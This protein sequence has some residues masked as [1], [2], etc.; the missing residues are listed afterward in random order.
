M[1]VISTISSLRVWLPSRWG[2]AGCQWLDDQSESHKL[3]WANFPKALGELAPKW[4]NRNRRRCSM[5]VSGTEK[6][7][8]NQMK[9]YNIILQSRK[10]IPHLL[11]C[12]KHKK[13]WVKQNTWIL[14]QSEVF[15]WK[16]PLPNIPTYMFEVTS[17][18]QHFTQTSDLSD[19]RLP[20]HWSTS[21]RATYNLGVY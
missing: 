9:Q 12:E 13:Q 7:S 16:N 18:W 11:S 19:H 6:M 20:C 4:C 10:S 15:S 21:E 8:K 3:W 14:W 1:L 17:S 5:V 2:P